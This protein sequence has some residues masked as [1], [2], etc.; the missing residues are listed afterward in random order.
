MITTQ[1]MYNYYYS[2][3]EDSCSV[4]ADYTSPRLFDTSVYNPYTDKTLYDAMSGFISIYNSIIERFLRNETPVTRYNNRMINYITPEEKIFISKA[5][6]YD[7]NDINLKNSVMEDCIRLIRLDTNIKTKY[8]IMEFSRLD[9]E[10][11]PKN[12][13]TA[14]VGNN[15]G[16]DDNDYI[17]FIYDLIETF[18]CQKLYNIGLPV[19]KI[20][21]RSV[22][23][24]SE[25]IKPSDA[26]FVIEYHIRIFYAIMKI[27]NPSI[28]TDF[29]WLFDRVNIIELIDIYTNAELMDEIWNFT[30]SIDDIENLENNNGYIDLMNKVFG[31][32]I[33]SR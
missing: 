7:Y 33:K 27:T 16:K 22:I 9:C 32:L 30:K 21:F 3:L 6:N 2:Q 14:F 24:L 12:Y 1:S 18:V 8:A 17:R 29:S 23:I 19:N 31:E 25:N 26:K 5:L 10:N 11:N 4:L 13:I 28:V 15:F 20:F